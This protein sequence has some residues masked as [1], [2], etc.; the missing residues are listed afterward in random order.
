MY[1]MRIERHVLYNFDVNFLLLKTLVT[2]VTDFLML[3]DKEYFRVS[4]KHRIFQALKIHVIILCYIG[5]GEDHIM[6]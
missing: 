3:C 1:N 6:D 2:Y 4:L 5:R